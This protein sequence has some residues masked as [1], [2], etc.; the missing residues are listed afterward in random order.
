MAERLQISAEQV[1]GGLCRVWI[2]ADQQSINGNALSVTENAIDRISR[3]SGLAGAMRAEHW[4]N[5]S[6]GRLS[7]PHFD[8][9]NGKTA[10]QRALTNKRVETHRKRESNDPSVTP[11]LPEKRREEKTPVPPSGAFLR[12][13]ETWPS[14]SRKKSQ[15]KCLEVWRKKGFDQAIDAICAHVETSK[16]SADWQKGYVPAPLVYLNQRQWEGADLTADPG[17]VTPLYRREGVM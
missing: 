7:L 6:D 3:V 16:L 9:H 13:W 15:G 17:T 11:A 14:G 5:G 10:K 12:F 1:L 2:W 8:R 4:I